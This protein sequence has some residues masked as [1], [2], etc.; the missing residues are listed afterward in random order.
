MAL[1]DIEEEFNGR[2]V[3]MHSDPDRLVFINRNRI[4]WEDGVPLTVEEIVEYLK[5]YGRKV[6]AFSPEEKKLV[7]CFLDEQEKYWNGY[8]LGIEFDENGD[9]K[10]KI[11]DG[12]I[13]SS[14]IPC[15]C[16]EIGS[17]QVDVLTKNDYDAFKERIVK[18]GVYTLL[19]K[20]YDMRKTPFYQYKCN[21]CG[22]IWL[23]P[24]YTDHFWCN[25]LSMISKK[26]HE[27]YLSQHRIDKESRKMITLV[28]VLII[29]ILLGI[30]LLA[31]S[32]A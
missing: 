10:Y 28:M 1:Y 16:E 25:K 30:V 12:K 31:I 5:F 18:D 2:K 26:A 24:P 21:R 6:R 8:G 4:T 14:R 3:I 22:D 19:D 27:A 9:P 20:T 11:E 15:I 13:Y 17:N 23:M 32:L 7:V 29:V